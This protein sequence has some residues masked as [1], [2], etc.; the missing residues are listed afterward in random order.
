MTPKPA[1]PA[2]K[3]RLEDPRPR[4]PH[5]KTDF[6]V[7][8]DATDYVSRRE[9]TRFLGLSSAGLAA[10]T[11]LVAV[12]G[13]LPRQTPQ[14]PRVR[15]GRVEDFPPGTSQAFEYPQKGQFSLLVRHDDGTFSAFGQKCPHLG[16][17]VY[18]A[19]HSRK[20]ECPCHEGFFNART[21]DVISGPPQRGLNRVE[22]ELR[23]GEVWAVGGG[24]H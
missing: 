19:P 1:T 23:D 13:S 12:A 7:D 9:F 21:G 17:A 4:Q 24:G 14:A 22:L 6:S 2:Q 5:W 15:L 8:W 16:C 18:Y 11:T 20:L 10:G 3:D